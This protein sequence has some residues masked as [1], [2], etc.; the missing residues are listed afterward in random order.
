MSK[1]HNDNKKI[2]FKKNI[3][4]HKYLWITQILSKK[5]MFDAIDEIMAIIMSGYQ[6]TLK[7]LPEEKE[8]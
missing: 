8:T 4:N 1:G 7:A 3:F 2:F 6:K 5:V